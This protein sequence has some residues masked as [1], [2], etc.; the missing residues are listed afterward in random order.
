MHFTKLLFSPKLTF[1]RKCNCKKPLFLLISIISCQFLGVHFSGLHVDRRL[2]PQLR[3]NGEGAEPRDGNWEGAWG[4][5]EVGNDWRERLWFTIA[6]PFLTLIVLSYAFSSPSSFHKITII[7]HVIAG[8]GSHVSPV[9]LPL[10][11]AHK[12]GLLEPVDWKRRS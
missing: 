1:L 12:E 5:W 9:I 6:R 4:R 3:G 7:P 8:G 2:A 10:S 11:P